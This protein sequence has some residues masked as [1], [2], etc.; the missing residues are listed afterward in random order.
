MKRLKI[1]GYA[2]SHALAA[3]I[4]GKAHWSFCAMC[5]EKCDQEGNRWDKVVGVLD[6]VFGKYHCERS[7]WYCLDLREGVHGWD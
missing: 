4:W 6:L 3:A 2:L 5:W 7:W 1:V